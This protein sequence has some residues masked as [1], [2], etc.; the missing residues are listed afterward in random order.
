M[1][2]EINT[3]KLDVVSAE[4]S[5]FSGVVKS[6]QVTGIEGQLGIRHGHAPLLTIIKPGRV[7]YVL[8]NDSEDVLYV[9][10]GILEVQPDRVTVLAD[11]AIRGEDI[12]TQK[13]EEAIRQAKER[14][15]NNS[16]DVDYAAAIVDLSK[17]LAQLKV[18]QITKGQSNR[19]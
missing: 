19:R 10:G 5:L 11:T 6:M 2:E 4:M 18:A 7:N 17:A 1:A 12:D 3:F 8:E 9:S 15:A 14:I 13:A 16:G